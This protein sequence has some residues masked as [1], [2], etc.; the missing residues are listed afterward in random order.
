MLNKKIKDRL[1]IFLFGRYENRKWTL[2][3]YNAIN[4]TK[5]KNVDDIEI[6]TIEDHIYMG[7]KNDVSFLIQS[8]L[9]LYEQQS[10]YNPNMPLRQLMYLGDL[11]QKYIIA[12]EQNI[13][14]RKKVRLPVPKLITFFNGKS[15]EPDQILR[16][17]D[18]LI[19][20]DDTVDSDVEV[21]VHM[22][23]ICYD[24][25]KPVLLNCRPLY[26]YSWFIDRINKNKKNSMNL[27]SAVDA[28]IKEMP[29]DFV[30]RDLLIANRAEVKDM[31]LTEYD[32]AAT[33][34]MFREEGREEGRKEGLSFL[35]S[36]NLRLIRAG[37]T[38]DIEKA[39]TDPNALMMYAEEFG[40]KME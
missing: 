35:N 29:K 28:T 13:Y 16:L 17:S 27:E 18:L 33:M 32:E 7:M 5:Y 22:I 24:E 6:T 14:G 19:K 23:N 15:N 25:S 39:A 12:T 20:D 30:I 9:N 2:D 21:S 4:T 10:T 37:R 40:I 11:Y 36:I 38:A 31:C 34:E 1:F 8:T 26:E 3:L